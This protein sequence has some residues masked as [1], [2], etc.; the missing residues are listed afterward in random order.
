MR[1]SGGMF[2]VS[3]LIAANANAAPVINFEVLPSGSVPTDRMMI[4]DQ[5]LSSL[6]VRFSLEGGGAPVLARVGTPQTAFAGPPNDTSPDIPA[7]NQG[8][9]EYFLTDDGALSGLSAKPL[10][11]DYINPTNAAGGDILDIDFDERW[12]IDARDD[13]GNVLGS[14]VLAAGDA[15]TG[16]GLATRWAFSFADADISSIRLAG[17]RSAAGRF[18]LAFDNFTPTTVPLPG[19]AWMLGA[20]DRKSVV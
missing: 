16:D 19:A 2:V 10:I 20:A 5:F 1:L 11:I 14:V 6:G 13:M 17:E 9:G 4:S 8:V 18:G 7:A 12:T 15:G 3:A